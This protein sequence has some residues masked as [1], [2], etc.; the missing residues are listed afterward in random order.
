MN[1]YYNYNNIISQQT[2]LCNSNMLLMNTSKIIVAYNQ[3]QKDN[4]VHLPP[5]LSTY[6]NQNSASRQYPASVPRIPVWCGQL[7]RPRILNRPV[8]LAVGSRLPVPIRQSVQSGKRMHLAK[9]DVSSG[10]IIP[11]RQ[12]DQ[13]KKLHRP[14]QLYVGSKLPI[15]IHDGVV[16]TRIFRHR[17]QSTRRYSQS[18]PMQPQQQQQQQLCYTRLVENS[19][20]VKREIFD[21]K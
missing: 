15:S 2:S 13:P 7:L 9:M 11:L 12:L 4:T 6:Q 18:Q 5:S 16:P 3:D 20:S 14:V 8:R 21:L 17:D 10:Q 1:Y 19:G